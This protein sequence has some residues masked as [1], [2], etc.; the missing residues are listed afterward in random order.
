[1]KM[2]QH[3]AESSKTKS[4]ASIITVLILIIIVIAGVGVLSTM[5]IKVSK[6][7]PTSSCVNY[8]SSSIEKACYLNEGEIKVII[9]KDTNSPSINLIGFSF[10]PSGSKWELTGKKCTDARIE[11]NDYNQYCKVLSAGEKLSYIL[12]ASEIEKQEE[13]IVY[14]SADNLKCQIGKR[15]IDVSC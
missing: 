2:K 6:S 7:P 10:I 4:Q 14:F 12:N 13:V 11:G 15:K 3:P 1:M 9:N 5:V 8:L